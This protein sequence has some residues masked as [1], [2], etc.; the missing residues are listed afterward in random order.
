MD[1]RNKK[2][3]RVSARTANAKHMVFQTAD[4]QKYMIMN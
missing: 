2:M 3:D 4:R 1:L